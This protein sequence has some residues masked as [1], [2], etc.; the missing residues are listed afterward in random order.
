MKA[1]TKSIFYEPG[2]FFRSN[3]HK[4]YERRHKNAGRYVNPT[5][6]GWATESKP[7]RIS[8]GVEINGQYEEVLV[9]HYFKDNWGRMTAGRVQAIKDTLPDEVE[10]IENQS[11]SGATYYTV[12]DE[13]MDN[14]L[15]AAKGA[16]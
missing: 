3:G 12:A 5:G 13:T 15:A 6:F 2:E 7:S 1:K 9:D 11:Y 10:I 4:G 16:K 8:L 14:W